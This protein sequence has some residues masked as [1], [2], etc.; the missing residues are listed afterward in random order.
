MHTS[1]FNAANMS[2]NINANHPATS[3]ERLDL[4]KLNLNNECLD[5]FSVNHLIGVPETTVSPTTSSRHEMNDDKDFYELDNASKLVQ[6]DD[7]PIKNADHQ[8]L[9]KKS[10]DIQVLNLSQNGLSRLPPASLLG[11]FSNLEFIDL[12]ENLFESIHLVSLVR[13]K[14]LKE[15]NLSSNMLKVLTFVLYFTI[16]KFVL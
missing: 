9:L 4:E 11:L 6:S 15:L 16:L 8:K 13:F 10:H 3:L 14:S 5:I 1:A 2:L 7:S 12:S